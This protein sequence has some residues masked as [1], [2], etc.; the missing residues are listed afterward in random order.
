MAEKVKAYMGDRV[1]ICAVCKQRQTLHKDYAWG[2]IT[3]RQWLP[4]VGRCKK[5]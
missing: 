1:R 3:N 2:R 4:L 5:P